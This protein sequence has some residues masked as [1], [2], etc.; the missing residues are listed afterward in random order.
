MQAQSP[1]GHEPGGPEEGFGP[2]AP[3]LAQS[4]RVPDEAHGTGTRGPQ[5]GQEGRQQD[6]EEAQGQHRDQG[7]RRQ[8]EAQT[9]R[10]QSTEPAHRQHR[11]A[12]AQ[13][14]EQQGQQQAL[15][16][17]DA[18]DLPPRRAHGPQHGDLLPL[19]AELAAQ[20]S[21]D[22]QHGK[23]QQAHAQQQDQDP[24]AFIVGQV[25]QDPY[26]LHVLGGAE[27]EPAPDADP[28]DRETPRGGGHL[29][30][31]H[32][33]CKAQ[34]QNAKT[35]ARGKGRLRRAHKEL[36]QADVLPIGE[37]G[38]ERFV[39]ELALAQHHAHQGIGPGLLRSFDGLD[40]QAH[41]VAQLGLGKELVQKI[42]LQSQLARGLRHP[43]GP[44]LSVG[45]RRAARVVIPHGA[46][47]AA[48][49]IVQRSGF[50]GEAL[51]QK[52]FPGLR[53]GVI[54]EGVLPA[55]FPLQL[56]LVA[57]IG[58]QQGQYHRAGQKDRR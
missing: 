3:C 2:E 56:G 40:L 54:N 48:A 18:A 57:V 9:V 32:A 29:V 27:V 50:G 22:A 53:P 8:P 34:E 52:L 4:L 42:Q 12:D 43:A 45:Q 24:K 16:P 55:V 33:V 37:V 38:A 47:A 10:R 13:G 20:G 23:E 25:F 31:P 51:P 49:Q 46:V 58:G 14:R 1:Q 35:A 21:R 5:Q 26:I 44:E 11:R 7:E 28:E 17:E 41:A 39:A 15:P 36:G 19:A 30:Q 6:E